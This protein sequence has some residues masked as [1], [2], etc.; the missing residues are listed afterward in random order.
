[1]IFF[2]SFASSRWGFS[3]F[4]LLTFIIKSCFCL[5]LLSFFL[6]LQSLWSA[7]HLNR[8]IGRLTTSLIQTL[9][10]LLLGSSLLERRLCSINYRFYCTICERKRWGEFNKRINYNTNRP[11]S[12]LVRGKRD[13]EW[14]KE[15][16]VSFFYLFNV[17]NIIK[18]RSVMFTL[19]LCW[20]SVYFLRLQAAKCEL[21]KVQP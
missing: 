17:V 14:Q 15:E 7:V 6:C 13:L 4:L 20:S 5:E 9:A 8:Y 21:N 19:E 16:N 2:W 18:N 10:L 3:P 11:F 12:T 1:M